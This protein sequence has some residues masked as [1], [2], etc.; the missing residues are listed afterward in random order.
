MNGKDLQSIYTLAVQYSSKWCH[1]QWQKLFYNSVTQETL[2]FFFKKFL[3][4]CLFCV[5]FSKRHSCAQVLM[6][7]KGTSMLVYTM[8]SNAYLLCVCD[9]RMRSNK[10]PQWFPSPSPPWMRLWWNMGFD[11]HVFKWVLCCI[12]KTRCPNNA[13]THNTHPRVLTYSNKIYNARIHD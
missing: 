7:D 2:V 11:P 4:L 5:F 3:F 9:R 10:S 6:H 12:P 1:N 8:E 13:I